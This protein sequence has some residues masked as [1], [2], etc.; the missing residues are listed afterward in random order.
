LA[1]IFAIGN[2]SVFLDPDTKTMLA[3]GSPKTL[4][5]ESTDAKIIQFLTRG[6][7]HAK[8]QTETE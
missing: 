8:N 7:G 1:S 5:A 6:E 3:T 4:L 2:N